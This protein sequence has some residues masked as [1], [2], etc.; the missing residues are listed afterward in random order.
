[1]AFGQGTL[2]L[3]N[4]GVTPPGGYPV[5][6]VVPL[7]IVKAGNPTAAGIQFDISV[8]A[9]AATMSLSPA[10][11]MAAL[12]KILACGTSSPIRCVLVGLANTTPIPD[13]A[14]VVATVTLPGTASN[15]PIQVTISAAIEADPAGNG[16]V[17]TVGNPTV[18]LPLKSGCDVNSDGSVG[19]DDTQA[20][21][22]AIITKATVL[23]FDLDSNSSVNVLDAQIAATGATPPNFVCTAH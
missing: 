20:I 3:T 23:S 10:P 6:A 22:N 18:S 17:V 11:A 14:V 16:L 19:A 13:G 7:N 15:N 2:S 8:P 9:G 5:G 21:V 1:M 4:P 12:G